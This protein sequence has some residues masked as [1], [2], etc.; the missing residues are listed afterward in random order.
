[1]LTLL[2][3]QLRS[4]ADG[5]NALRSLLGVQRTLSID[6]SLVDVLHPHTETRGI[7]GQLTS[8]F[9][10]SLLNGRCGKIIPVA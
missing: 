9:P 2:K 6:Y 8:L 4:T 10:P 1:M 7:W 3:A 5:M